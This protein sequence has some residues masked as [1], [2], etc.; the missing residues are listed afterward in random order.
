MEKLSY[1]NK[2]AVKHK[3]SWLK[4]SLYSFATLILLII[5]SII[6][7]VTLVNPNQY[8]ATI[9]QSIKSQTGANL[10]LG[11]I[12]WQFFPEIGLKAD[13]VVLYSAN[14]I[15]N[16]PLLSTASAKILVQIEPLIHSKFMVNQIIIADTNV[17]LIKNGNENNWT[18]NFPASTTITPSN[19]IK[20][21]IF[22]LS[23]IKLTN[24][25]LTYSDLIT[26]QTT[27]IR[28][29][30]LEINHDRGGLMSFNGQNNSLILDKV[31]YNLNDILKGNINFSY[32]DGNYVGDISGDNFSIPDLCISLA[33]H[34]NNF[35][36]TP[37]RK[38]TYSTK[39]Q[40]NLTQLQIPEA[41]INLGIS[42]IKLNLNLASFNPLRG[43]QQLT[44]NQ[45]EASDYAY[46]KGYHLRL[47]NLRL[48]G[49]FANTNTDFTAN[50]N[51]QIG[52][53]TL[54][55]YNLHA[56]SSQIG[57]ILSNPLKIIAIPI[58]VSQIKNSVAAAGSNGQKDLNITSNLG[59][60]NSNIN[61]SQNQAKFNSLYLS[62]PDVK[63]SGNG[64]LDL[65]NKYLTA[66]INA[67]FVADPSSL[68]GK[69]VYPVTINGNNTVIDWN[70]VSAQLTKN[71]GGSLINTT[72]QV[73][74]TTT[75]A[76]KT[77]GSKIKSWF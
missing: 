70:S 57:S 34:C 55:G 26:H 38:V 16:T 31:N 12:S 32:Q 47:T 50:Q 29:I 77:I 54:Y 18:F 35:S 40:G 60:L 71:V 3:K 21:Y 52:N 36:A 67:Q 48:N 22:Q 74:S 24:F 20:N 75:G 27:A 7:I 45:V 64:N 76:V 51:L 56:L 73:G 6:A 65:N 1:K 2:Q 46:L 30:N 15:N 8:K 19:S 28:N 66:N 72:K 62:G 68:T 10:E 25:N 58:T 43:N 33:L 13:Q 23:K 11:T 39:F 63:A 4:I 37:W 61:I 44:I 49:N 5:V 14:P 9:I 59:S 42:T 69:I 17:N 53:L 41:M